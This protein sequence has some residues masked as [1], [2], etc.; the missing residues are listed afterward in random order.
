MAVMLVMAA[1]PFLIIDGY[2]LLHAAGLSLANYKQGDL[3]RQR[4]RLLALLAE[5]LSTEERQRCTIVFDAVDAPS[6]LDSQFEHDGMAVLFAK[7]G[8]EA[9]ELI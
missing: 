8:H 9:D 6:G 5:R 2:N 4:G 7:P 3:H 1:I